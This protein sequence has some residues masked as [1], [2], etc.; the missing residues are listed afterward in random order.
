MQVLVITGMSGSGKSTALKAFEDM[1]YGCVDNLP[2]TLLPAFLEVKEAGAAGPTRVALVMDIREETF[3]HR[4]REV[5]DQVRAAGFHLEVL[6]L[7]AKDEVLIRRFSQT[8]RTHPLSPQGSLT[9]GIRAERGQLA[10]LRECADRILDTSN[11][12]IHQLRQTLRTLYSPR[13]RLDRLILHL[14]S[15]GF[16]YGVPAEA[17]LVLDVRFLA[18]P[19]FDPALQPRDGRDPAVQDYV[20]RDEKTGEFLLRAEALLRFLVPLY[21]DEGKSYLVIAIGCTGGRHR[22]VAL[23]EHFRRMFTASREEVIVT[24]RDIEKEHPETGK[25]AQGW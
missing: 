24:H 20:L 23:V 2:V 8:R 11:F 16:K 10:A 13:T 12:N 17:N 5:F 1:G 15:F 18:N 9:E 25:G 14:V 6:F 19:Y 22:S 7:D 3:L 21:R 4:H